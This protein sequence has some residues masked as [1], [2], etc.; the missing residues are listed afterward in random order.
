[1]MVILKG[2]VK[3]SLIVA[4]YLLGKFSKQKLIGNRENFRFFF[5]IET[6][7]EIGFDSVSDSAYVEELTLCSIRQ[8]RQNVKDLG[9]DLTL[10]V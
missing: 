5:Q 10:K 6:S 9:G 1:M 7:K 2:C 3:I 8:G 4:I